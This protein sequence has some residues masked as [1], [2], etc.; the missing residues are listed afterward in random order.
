MIRPKVQEALL[1]QTDLGIF[2]EELEEW[3]NKP[4]YM[5]ENMY[6]NDGKLIFR[7]DKYEITP[8]AA[9]MP[10]AEIPIDNEIQT[11]LKKN[12]SQRLGFN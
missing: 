9:G 1:E 4:K 5:F 11:L 7:F 6:I 10:E 8:G 2:E 12:W 3:V